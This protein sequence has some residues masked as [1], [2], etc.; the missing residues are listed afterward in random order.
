MSRDDDI[1]RLHLARLPRDKSKKRRLP[2]RSDKK[3]ETDALL[4]I[5]IPPYLER[6]PECDI[7]S[8]V[9]TYF[10]TCVNHTKG[11]GENEVL[12]VATWQPSCHPCNGWIEA[13]HAIARES[14]HKESRHEIKSQE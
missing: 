14:G 8:P 2:Q 10:S 13:N 11:R 7:K 9:C 5:L 4:K 12:N 6:Y 1:E 3:E